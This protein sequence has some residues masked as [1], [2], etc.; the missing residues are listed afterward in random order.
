MP[1]RPRQSRSY[2]RRRRTTAWYNKRYSAKGLALKALKNIH[3]MKGMIN[4]EKHFRDDTVTLGSARSNI[5]SVNLIPQGDA[6]NHRSGNSVLVRSIYLRGRLEINSSVTGNTRISLI[7]IRDMQQVSDTTPTVT[8]V[9]TSDDPDSM[10]NVS[11]I[12]RY[13]VLWR[14][15][16]TLLPTTAGS[17]SAVDFHK[18]F[19]VYSHLR[20]NGTANTDIQKGGYY[21]MICSS[22]ST[23]YPTVSINT[24]CGYYDN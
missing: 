15:T 7:L 4:S 6:I 24:R 1:Y 13:K 22:E 3:Y 9:L 8:D 21:L 2:R 20:F 11:T 5:A 14:K 19:K 18:F 10:L 17:Q 12:G 16:Y 23:N